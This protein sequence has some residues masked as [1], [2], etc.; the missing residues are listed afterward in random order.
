MKT[1]EKKKEKKF[2]TVRHGS[3]PNCEQYT[4]GTTEQTLSTK[5]K[6]NMLIISV[7]K[8]AEFINDSFCLLEDYEI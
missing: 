2:T 5:K 7:H 3:K 4:A 6:Q 1:F 8:C